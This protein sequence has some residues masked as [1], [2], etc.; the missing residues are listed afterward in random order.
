MTAVAAPSP[1]A[2]VV[3]EQK[4]EGFI[5]EVIAGVKHE[6]SVIG[7]QLETAAQLLPAAESKII[8]LEPFVEGLGAAAGHPE[9]I[10]GVQAANVAMAGLNSFVATFTKATT[11][12]S[13]V[14]ATEAKAAITGA[15]QAYRDTVATYNA[16][17]AT[18]VAVATAPAAPTPVVTASPP[19]AS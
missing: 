15:Y 14:T 1:N 4:I 18:A 13:S 17:K 19:A 2:L 16:V 5:Q 7:Q 9:V 3:I 6:L 12:G 8:A 10:A 11:P